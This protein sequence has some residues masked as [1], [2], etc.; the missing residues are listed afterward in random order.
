MGALRALVADPS[1]YRHVAAAITMQS[2]IGIAMREMTRPSS[3][4]RHLRP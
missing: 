4:D 3:S 1:I 2:L